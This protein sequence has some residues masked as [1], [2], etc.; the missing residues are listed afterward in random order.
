MLYPVSTAWYLPVHPLRQSPTKRIC[1]KSATA[2]WYLKVFWLFW[3]CVLQVPLLLLMVQLP[4]AHH[5]PSSHQALPVSLKCSVSLF[6]LP[7]ASWQCVYPL[8]HLQ[9]LTL[10]HVSDVCLSRNCSPL[11]IWNTL[12][13]G[14]NFYA[15]NISPQS[16]HCSLAMCWLR[17]AMLTSGHC[18][19]APTSC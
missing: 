8:L 5:S 12:K 13:A 1:R 6:T 3:L 10:L 11:M 19:E 14:E 7:S 16:W 17:L 2:L 15:T 9:P 4:Q 18:S